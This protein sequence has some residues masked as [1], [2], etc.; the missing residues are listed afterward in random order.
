MEF[1]LIPQFPQLSSEVM[2]LAEIQTLFQKLSLVGFLLTAEREELLET[3][4]VQPQIIK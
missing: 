1:G 4:F 2:P 3:T